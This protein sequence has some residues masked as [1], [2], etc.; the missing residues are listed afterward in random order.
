MRSRLNPLFNL[1]TAT[2]L[3]AVTSP[4]PMAASPR[5]RR[6]I[7]QDAN[8][9]QEANSERRLREQ[10]IQQSQEAKAELL[11]QQGT[12]QYRNSK[13][14]EALKTYQQVLAIRRAMVDESGEASALHNIGTIYYYLSQRGQSSE[15]LEQ[16]LAIRQKIGDKAGEK[17]TLHNIGVVNRKPT[18][19][20][21]AP[22]VSLLFDDDEKQATP[23]PRSAPP[24]L[25]IGERE[26]IS[27]PPRPSSPSRNRN[28]V[29]YTP[30]PNVAYPSGDREAMPSSR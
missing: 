20:L 21:S 10:R 9:A 8:P 6:N 3:L 18:F 27:D 28:T 22:H 30:P 17:R 15:F 12:Q 13:Y 23:H 5:G 2:L 7:M 4:L 24:T 11:S 14:Q 25:P 29:P 19:D 26:I 16:A 1:V